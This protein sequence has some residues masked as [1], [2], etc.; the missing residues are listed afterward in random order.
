MYKLFFDGGKK[1]NYISY[2]I[3]IYHE[4][5]IIYRANGKINNKKFSCNAAEYIGLIIGLISAKMLGIQ[6]LEIYGDS[7]IVINQ[8]NRK[9][10]IKSEMM[11]ELNDFCRNILK[12]FESYS[13]FWIPRK[14][15]GEAHRE[16][17]IG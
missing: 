7:L 3:V 5:K 14:M 16:T 15:N 9:Y 17:K 10:L 6:R 4:D 8:L 11:Q 2:G 12:S 13:I 1:N